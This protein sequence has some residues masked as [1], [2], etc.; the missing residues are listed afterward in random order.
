MTAH[1]PR[2]PSSLYP[3]MAEAKRRMRKRRVLILVLAVLIGGGAAGATVALSQ[4]NGFKAAALCPG[5]SVYV[6]AVPRY[7]AQAP[8]APAWP[9]GQ[10]GDYWEWMSRSD[11]LKVGNWIRVSLHGQAWRVAG[12][13]ALAGDCRFMGLEPV[14]GTSRPPGGS[15]GGR[16][17]L[18]PVN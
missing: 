4:S 14:F 8:P 15:V 7:P 3:L 11:A 10:G 1:A 5:A 6:Y 17:I 13:A 18:Q 2:L 9:P 12:I 16:L